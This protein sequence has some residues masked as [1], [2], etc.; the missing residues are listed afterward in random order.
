[1]RQHFGGEEHQ[2]A[3][4]AIPAPAG[5]TLLPHPDVQKLALQSIVKVL[6][7]VDAL[8][9][10]ADMETYELIFV[11]AYG[12][13]VWGEVSDKK[14]F[15]YLQADQ[16]SPCSFCTNHRLVDRT[17]QP[18]GVYVWEFQ[19]TVNKHW[20]Q[21]RDIA[22]T[23]VDGR[24]ARMETAV[25][26]T[27]MKQNEARLEAA[28]RRAEDLSMSDP[29]TGTGNRRAFFDY[30]RVQFDLLVRRGQGQL[31]FVMLDV[32]RF[33]E[34]NDRFGHAVGDRALIAICAVV[35]KHIRATDRLFRIGGEE[36]VILMLDCNAIQA[37][38]RAE[39]VRIA[40]ATLDLHHTDTR[41]PLSCS[42]GIAQYRQGN[43]VDTLL[44]NADRALYFAKRNGRNQSWR[45]D[46]ISADFEI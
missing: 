28:L 24:L 34:V 44:A 9:Y 8:V 17:G 25:D 15:Q 29:L 3:S 35:Q 18:N 33:K 20:Y 13:K 30:A 5:E 38:V 27:G 37:K 41:V 43:D 46:E 21:C 23:W 42:F 2:P 7:S 45:Y 6:D 26:I 31:S 40:I 32:D 14:C 22:I 1:M 39:G 4:H 12:R 16:D 10:V 36:F 19:N 11:N